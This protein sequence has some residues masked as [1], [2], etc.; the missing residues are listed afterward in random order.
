[1]YFQDKIDQVYKHIPLLILPFR[2]PSSTPNNA[3]SMFIS[4]HANILDQ[5]T[6]MHGVSS[7]SVILLMGNSPVSIPADCRQSP[8]GQA[9]LVSQAGFVRRPS[10]DFIA[11]PSL[12]EP[13]SDPRLLL[14]PS[15]FLIQ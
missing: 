3:N 1:V 8:F 13:P 12:T 6:T 10:S 4:P 2:N 9:G 15:K 14:K 5:E 11:I 7:G